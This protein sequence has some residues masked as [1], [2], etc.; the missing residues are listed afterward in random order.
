MNM[1]EKLVRSVLVLNKEELEKFKNQTAELTKALSRHMKRM[2]PEIYLAESL[3]GDVEEV[4]TRILA[5]YDMVERHEELSLGVVFDESIGL[6]ID[7]MKAL[8]NLEEG[9]N[10][11]EL[12]KLTSCF[13][14]LDETEKWKFEH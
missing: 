1:N 2:R 12:I 11:E 4:I 14:I 7:F 8:R 13:T 3:I 10:P 5:F 6:K 9:T